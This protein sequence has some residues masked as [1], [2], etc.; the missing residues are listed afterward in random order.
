MYRA[1]HICSTYANFYD[2]VVRIKGILKENCFP[3][4]LVD[5]VIK[6][7]L[8]QKFSKQPPPSCEEK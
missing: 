3:L 7:L 8:D 4:P 1:F 2:E 5:R 6:T